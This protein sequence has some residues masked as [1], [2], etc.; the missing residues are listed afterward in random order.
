MKDN[1]RA[2]RSAIKSGMQLILFSAGP[3]GKIIGPQ[4]AKGRSS[5]VI[6]VGNTLVHWSRG[7]GS[8]AWLF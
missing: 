1:D 6:D 2:V 5:V 8:G 4:I 7:E 3:G